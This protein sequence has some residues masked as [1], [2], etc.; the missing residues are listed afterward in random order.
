MLLKGLFFARLKFPDEIKREIID[1]KKSQNLGNKVMVRS[2]FNGED[3]KGFSAA[4]LYDS[5]LCRD[6]SNLLA[7]ISQVWAS[8]W[9]YEA[10]CSR[11]KHNI[12][13]DLIKPTVIIQDFVDADYRF[14]IYTND[15][16]S[17]D[18][19]KILIEMNSEKSP[20]K[21]PTDPYIIKYDKTAKN[22]EIESLERKGRKITLDENFNIIEPEPVNDPLIED[23]D[24]WQPLLEKV[25]RAALEVEEEFGEAQDIEGGITLGEDRGIDNAK[26][27]FWQARA[28]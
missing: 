28:Q 16:E 9:N 15:P 10:Y 4:G 13:H 1:F 25:C 3:A 2:S 20:D 6:D 11:K 8:K 18:N 5:Y 7:K 21:K 26:I 24:Q 23:I 19:S 22:I 17:N 14:T 12:N 27:Y